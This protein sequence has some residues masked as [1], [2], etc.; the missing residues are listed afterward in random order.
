VDNKTIKL[1]TID[2]ANYQTRVYCLP[3][4]EWRAKLILLIRNPEVMNLTNN[5]FTSDDLHRLDG[6]LLGYSKE[7]VDKFIANL[8]K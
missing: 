8:S 3:T 5:M 4:E 7:S 6:I 2:N 1:Y